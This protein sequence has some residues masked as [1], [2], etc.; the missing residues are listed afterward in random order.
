[1]I[2][3]VLAKLVTTVL[4]R[5]GF[6][7]AAER[8]SV[9]EFI[10][11]FGARGWT[12]SRVLGELVKWKIRLVFLEAAASAPQIGAVTNLVNRVVLFVPNLVVALVVLMVDALLA[13]VL[14][15]VVRGATAEAGF[16]NPG[17]V[18]RV[19]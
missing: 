13:R 14:A 12:A 10:Q 11:K 4:Q 15:G 8:T 1:V 9:A 6:E 5:V 2:A 7:T 19:A 16:S 17:L 3:G 18:G